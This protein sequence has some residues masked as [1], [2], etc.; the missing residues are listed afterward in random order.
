[1][2]LE[3][4]VT[5]LISSI[6]KKYFL[7]A[8]IFILIAACSNVKKTNDEKL[9]QIPKNE[10]IILI[11]P[12]KNTDLFFKNEAS[13]YGLSGLKTIHSYAI[14]LNQD[15][16]DDLVFIDDYFSTPKFY[17]FDT[18]LKKF[19]K[20][21]SHFEGL[22][23]ASFLNFADFNNDGITDVIVGSLN[24]KTEMTKEE[25]KIFRGAIGSDSK[26]KFI[27]EKIVIPGILPLSNV[28]VFDFDLDG[29]LDLF[30]SN[31]FDHTGSNPKLIPNLLLKGDGFNFI[32]VSN[33]LTGEFDLYKSNKEYKSVAPTFG[34]TTCD[35]DQ[36]GFPD[37]LTN[38]SNGHFNKLWMNLE[39]EKERAFIDYGK[40]S[41]YAADNDGESEIKGGNNSFFSLCFDYN[42]DGILDI[43]IG[44]M[45]LKTDP[46]TRDRSAVLTGASLKFPPKF[47]R[48][49]VY[50]QEGKEFSEV[51][52]RGISF[53]YNLDG[54]KDIFIENAGFPP[55]TRLLL[56]KQN[57]DSSFEDFGEEVGIDLVNPSGIIYLDVNKDGILDLLSGQTD[58]RLKNRKVETYLFINKMGRKKNGSLKLNLLGIESNRDGIGASVY[59]KTDKSKYFEQAVYNY[60][61]LPSQNMKGIYFSFAEEIPQK[62]IISWPYGIKDRLGRTEGRVVHYD[63]KKLKLKSL[64]TELNICENGKIVT[65]KHDCR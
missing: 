60:G 43:F 52:R 19:I 59:L 15:N 62:L 64:H 7:Y 17:L 31:W 61:S 22:I 28:S 48:S 47:L 6:I 46:E 42:N 36:N 5:G 51:D 9:I 38:S 44:N 29:K 65:K 4:V 18:T 45:F 14:D 30:L 37:I 40:S 53:D 57:E 11:S 12:K 3:M 35:I 8:A 63:L 33:L 10:E 20:S 50:H 39:K 49:E 41:F 1:M 56:Y 58:L 32:N 24:Q 25:L 55:E 21:D 34:A 2:L 23:R 54:R 26:I 16:F 13:S 27:D